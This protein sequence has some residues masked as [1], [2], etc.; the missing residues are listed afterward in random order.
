[1]LPLALLSLLSSLAT[2]AAGRLAGAYASLLVA[3]AA[4][5][6]LLAGALVTHL[7]SGESA[8][9][10]AALGTL[11]ALVSGAALLAEWGSVRRQGPLY[12]ALVL[13]LSACLYYLFGAAD[14]F[15]FYIGFEMVLVPLVVVIGI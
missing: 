9:L 15:S 3:L 1:M 4:S 10:G 11:T 6:G 7:L 8:G 2:L 13:A 12:P 14:L 5:V